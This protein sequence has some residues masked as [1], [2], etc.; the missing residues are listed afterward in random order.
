MASQGKVISE[1][2][3][4]IDPWDV[5]ACMTAWM[6]ADIPKIS[7]IGY[8]TA[9]MDSTVSRFMA[10]LSCRKGYLNMYLVVNLN[11]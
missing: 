10:L 2:A 11:G 6:A 9:K 3:Q 4:A 7:T 8:T 5:R 1:I